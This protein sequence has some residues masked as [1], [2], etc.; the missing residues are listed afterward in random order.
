MTGKQLSTR[1]KEIQELEKKA[2]L[3]SENKDY[4]L[5]YRAYM[6]VASKAERFGLARMYA[7]YLIKA[8]NA[9]REEGGWLFLQNATDCYARAGEREK[10][11][12]LLRELK[13]QEEDIS[14]GSWMGMARTLA[15]INQGRYQYG[16]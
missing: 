11:E 12:D 2:D 6:Q 16:K 15:D 4:H 1:L 7:N 5:A 13:Y 10:V 3:H 8:G 14:G 9:A